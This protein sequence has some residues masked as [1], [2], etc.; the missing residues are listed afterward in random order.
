MEIE[1]DESIAKAAILET[2]IVVP[3]QLIGTFIAIDS[4]DE[5]FDEPDDC[6]P[7]SLLPIDFSSM[8]FPPDKYTVL[9]HP[10]ISLQPLGLCINTLFCC[11]ICLQ[12][13]RAVEW[14]G[15]P[16]HL[17]QHLKY[18][19]IPVTL[20]DDLKQ[21]FKI[22]PLAD[23]KYFKTPVPPVFG[24][25]IEPNPFHF[26]EVC[27]RGYQHPSGLR[28]HQYQSATRSSGEAHSGSRI[29]YAQIIT[30]GPNRRY[31]QVD[32]TSL[33]PRAIIDYANLF[34]EQHPLPVDFSKLPMR[35]V[36][37]AQNLGQ[38]FY[39]ERWTSF[40]QGYQPH[41][42]MDAC[43]AALP[44][45]ALGEA[46]KQAAV[47]HLTNVQTKITQQQAFGLLKK[48]AQICPK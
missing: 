31:F 29:G 30:D 24:V 39:R 47:R 9:H 37:D 6:P 41:E 38:F 40:V 13:A 32:V 21:T 35:S 43:R 3:Q 46:I 12:C 14:A 34:E 5:T 18:V 25:P 27:H 19:D 33:R 48:I 36:E 1:E 22:V 15:L 4:D 26:C 8:T 16:R 2:E 23:V 28:S 17:H 10:S 7:T 44:T 11:V 42:I 20:C 45:D